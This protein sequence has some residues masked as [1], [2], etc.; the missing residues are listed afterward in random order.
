MT[1]LAKNASSFRTDITA[2]V[3]V[4]AAFAFL[5]SLTTAQQ[6]FDA[7]KRPDALDCGG[8]VERRSGVLQLFGPKSRDLFTTVDRARDRELHARFVAAGGRITAH[9]GLTTMAA[10]RSSWG[11]NGGRCQFRW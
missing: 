9:S 8:E 3:T 7:P 4:A 11:I 6:V 2:A 10:S 5:P 1:R